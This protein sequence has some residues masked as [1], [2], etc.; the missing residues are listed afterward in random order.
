MKQIKH[1]VLSEHTNELYKKEAVSSISLSKEIASKINELVDAY[2]ELNKMNLAKVQEQD[3]K[4]RKGIIY[5][6][7]NLINT[8]TDLLENY[9][10]NGKLN[11]II[12]DS[13]LSEI[14]KF[15]EEIY[16]M[17]NVKRYG[18]KG[19]GVHDDTIAI[20]NAITEAKENN[21][22]LVIE[23]GKYLINKDLSA[24]YIKEIDIKGEIICLNNHVFEVGGSSSDGTS[25]NINI[26][27]CSS[28]KVI[29]LK[30]SI[31]NI[32]YCELLHLV[33]DGD[34]VTSSSIGYCQ[35]YGAY[36]KELIIDSYGEEIG[37]INENIF[38]I[39]RIENVTIKG[40]YL[41]NNNRFEHINLEKGVINLEKARNN[42]FS[43]RCEGGVT[44]NSSNDSQTNFL[45]KEYY[46]RH[47]F[48]D[49]IVE[50]SFGNYSYHHV[51]KLQNEKELLLIDKN[52]KEFPVKA[53][54]FEE[55]GTFKGNSFNDIFHSNLIKI[56]KTFCLK[57]NSDQAN[58]RVQ[59]NFYD[60]NKNRITAKVDNFTDG[61]MSYQENNDWSYMV[62][63][64][65]SEDAVVFFPGKAKYVEYKVIF[66]NNTNVKMNYVSVK[67][68]KLV[69]TNI[70]ITNNVEF[71]IYTSIPTQGYFKRG[72]IL[73]AKSPSAGSGLG[74][75]CVEAGTPGVWKNFGTIAS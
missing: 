18:A 39:K 48:S 50:D 37:W 11:T 20:F 51:N 56:D 49:S 33:A 32:N 64:N 15:R 67:L 74:I 25:Y 14:N 6:K 2:N 17:G 1:Y 7:D 36:A 30:N 47:Y 29:G 70:H 71:G 62:S 23:E 38:R 54:L 59:M 40:N 43:A 31:L 44:I 24:R 12:T 41:H 10:E 52:I 58:I 16:P 28:I 63:A 19:D 72:T 8:I 27:K 35:F 26:N 61:R 42:Y 57:V 45:E 46:Y 55:D 73:Y 60:E 4:I 75:V 66:G 13:V 53:V 65:V 9:K 5:M 69:N 34:D 21:K 3:G 22:P 68:I